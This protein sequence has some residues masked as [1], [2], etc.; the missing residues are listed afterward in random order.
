MHSTPRLPAPHFAEMDRHMPHNRPYAQGFHG[1]VPEFVLEGKLITV[2][3]LGALQSALP[4][5]PLR[6]IS[7][8]SRCIPPLLIKVNNAAERVMRTSTVCRETLPYRI[9]LSIR[10][11]SVPGDLLLAHHPICSV[12]AM[13]MLLCYMCICGDSSTTRRPSD[14]TPTYPSTSRVAA[15]LE[16]CL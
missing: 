16:T 1:P 4:V 10:V 9:D 14:C 3:R 15:P 5:P 6:Q 2:G 7:R 11:G 8:P 13:A 12:A